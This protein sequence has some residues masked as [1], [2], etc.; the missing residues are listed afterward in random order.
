MC[1]RHFPSTVM[2]PGD[3]P[4]MVMKT[5]HFHTG[6]QTVKAAGSCRLGPDSSEYLL[7]PVSWQLVT[8]QR[9]LGFLLMLLEFHGS[10]LVN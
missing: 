1:D 6:A 3:H 9:N 5:G 2:G 4:Q 8:L 10:F 7:G